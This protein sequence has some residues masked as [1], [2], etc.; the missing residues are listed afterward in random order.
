MTKQERLQALASELRTDCQCEFWIEY[1][2]NRGWFAIA[3]EARWIGDDGEY[4]GRVYQEARYGL[5]AILG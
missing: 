4:L 5:M 2:P 3:S 1:R